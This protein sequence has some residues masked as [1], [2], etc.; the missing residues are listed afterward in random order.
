MEGE[1]KD[2]V[3]GASE[4]SITTEQVV[5]EE[6]FRWAAHPI[7]GVLEKNAPATLCALFC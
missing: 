2:N 1:E 6:A 5:Q 7:L 4:G 3:M